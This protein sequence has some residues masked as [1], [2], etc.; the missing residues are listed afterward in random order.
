METADRHKVG[1]P[2]G[3]PIPAG[4]PTALRAMPVTTGIT[5]GAHRAAVLTLLDM[6]TQASGSAHPGW[7]HDTAPGTPG[8]AVV[9]LTTPLT[10][11]VKNICRLQCRR[12]GATFSAR[13]RHLRGQPAGRADCAVDQG[14]GHFRAARGGGQIAVAGQ[15]LDDADAGSVL[16]KMGGKAMTKRMQL[17]PLAD[18]GGGTRRAAGRMQNLNVDG[19][20]LVPAREKAG[21]LVL[22]A[23]GRPAGQ[24]AAAPG[25][26]HCG[27]C[28]LCHAQPG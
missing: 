26:S 4:L 24:R 13:R 9:Q 19:F 7:A 2:R 6:R 20:G 3:K 16:R 10:V 12:H 18:A 15:N 5:G 25:A 8:M 21:P 1:L 22:P 23:A 28:R 17:Y 11:T 27:P 14:V